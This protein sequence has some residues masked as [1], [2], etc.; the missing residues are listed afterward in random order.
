M[1]IFG[2]SKNRWRFLVYLVFSHLPEKPIYFPSKDTYVWVPLPPT[3]H[4]AVTS[5]GGLA[6]PGHGRPEA[7]ALPAQAPQRRGGAKGGG[8]TNGLAVA[9]N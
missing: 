1:S 9:Q 8:A 2:C 3:G 5:A 6:L 7:G 4:R